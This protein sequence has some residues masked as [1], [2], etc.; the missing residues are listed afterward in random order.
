MNMDKTSSQWDVPLSISDTLKNT[1]AG[2]SIL[3]IAALI[4]AI[5]AE[6]NEGAIANGEVIPFGKTK[7]I[8]HLEGGIVRE[9]L[10]KDGD[11][12]SADHGLLVLDDH[13]AKAQLTLAYTE[14]ASRKALVARLL[15]E[16]DG[17]TYEGSGSSDPAMTSQLRIFE[18]R[19]QALRN[20]IAALEKRSTGLR[21]EHEAWTRRRTALGELTANA[22]EE[23]TLNQQL[24]EKNF[25]SRPRLLALDNQLSDRV[26]AKGETEAELARVSQ[27]LSDTTLQ[28][29]KLKSDWLNAVLDELRKAQDELAVATEKLQ[30][31]EGRLQR[32]RIQSPHEGIVKGLRFTTIGAVIPSGGIVL[33]I[34]P[35]SDKMIVEAKVLPDDIDVVRIGTKARIRFTAYKARAH[36]AYDGAVIDISPSTFHDD[37]TGMLYYLARVEVPEVA[38]GD[39]GNLLLQP[40]MLA[41]VSFTGK[42]RSPIRYLLDPIT[43]S[44]TRAFREE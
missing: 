28:I 8:Q 7:T 37:K 12:V 15:A 33:D 22:D 14:W 6:L 39:N 27:R 36:V 30:V 23:R 35:V 34:V 2:L 3:F 4:W 40:G 5:F 21:D 26:A 11:N 13:E 29:S 43:Q 42:S 44:M 32:T 25:I 1:I 24:Y 17:K 20:E 38:L 31:A 10:V 19:R 9:I 16:R 18:I 41:E